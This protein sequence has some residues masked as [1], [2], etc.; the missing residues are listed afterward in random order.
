MKYAI[1]THG[2]SINRACKVL[3]LSRS[4]YYNKPQKNEDDKI[5][6]ILLQLAKKHIRVV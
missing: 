2:I 1:E 5:K 4:V 3:D 6:L